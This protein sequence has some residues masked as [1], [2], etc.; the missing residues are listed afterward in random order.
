M[1][2]IVLK[3]WRPVRISCKHPAT[4]P[5]IPNG[6]EML[7][8]YTVH[9]RMRWKSFCIHGCNE[10]YDGGCE[11]GGLDNKLLLHIPVLNKLCP[12]LYRNMTA[13]I[14]YYEIDAHPDLVLGYV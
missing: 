5:A 4:R 10:R 1:F 6:I 2:M 12:G 14:L 3:M 13:C 9:R 8:G 7:K 11:E